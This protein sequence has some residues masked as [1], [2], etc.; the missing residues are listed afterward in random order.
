MRFFSR[1]ASL[2]TRFARAFGALLALATVNVVAFTWGANQRAATFEVLHEAVARHSALT[3]ARTGLEDHAK[4]VKVVS[5]LFGVEHAALS[6]AERQATLRSIDALREQ[7]A[8]VSDR[9]A[10]RDAL[11][12]ELATVRAR[13]DSL[14]LSWGRFYR[15]QA[16]DPGGAIAEVAVTAEPLARQ[17]LGTDLPAAIRAEHDRVD[18]ATAAF[19]RT[20]RAASVLM[21]AILA[22]SGL[23]GVALA[24][25]LSRDLLRDIGA[26]KS[27]VERFGAGEL[28]YRVSVEHSE[29]LEEVGESLNA[30]AGRLRQAQIDLEARNQELAH[31]AYRDPLTH[32]ANRTLFRQRVE[33]ALGRVPERAGE[34]FVLFIDLDD[35]K[36]VNDTLG[37]AAGDRLLVD[38]ASRLL[39]ATRGIDTV[40]RLGGDEFAILL[41]QV[42]GV[43]DAVIVAERVIGA[44]QAPFRLDARTVHVGASVGI[45]SGRDGRHAV[46]HADELLRNA[47]VAMYRAK[48]AGRGCHAVFEPEMHAAL[49]DRV[50]LEQ[51]LRDALR[52]DELTVGFQPI[53]ELATGRV[54]GF[55]ALARWTHARRGVVPPSVFVPLAEETGA[56]LALGRWMLAR[57]CREAVR[58]QAESPDGHPIGVSVNVSGRQVEDPSFVSDLRAVL[59]STGLAPA[60]LTLEITETV[61]MRESETT[62]RWLHEIKALGVRVAIDDFGTGYSSL[63]YLQHFPVDV[64]KIDKAFV[65]QIGEGRNDAAIARTIVTLAEM[66]GLRTV[67]EGIERP[68]QHA[69]LRALGCQLGQGFLYA[70]PL[71]PAEA[72]EFLRR[73]RSAA[74]GSE[75]TVRRQLVMAG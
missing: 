48:A 72:L 16:T 37:H 1:R 67:A 20:D 36:S 68:E 4:R 30:M 23:C 11:D 44:M 25:A 7:L 49:L 75:V 22:L 62:R 38:V 6:R 10:D 13:V 19:Q 27:G 14:T 17:L 45:A 12:A 41:P 28:A 64:L 21:W 29:E 8:T 42:R 34:L 26:L 3:E 73:R 51:E 66:L 24:Y 54:T 40:A 9:D 70:R 32:L 59:A 69:G 50:E 35:F 60:C 63:A 61:I 46:A 15:M 57:A 55:E 56:V 71:P 18:R 53:V 74:E 2:R 47:D 52:R 65:D 5:D 33:R 58:W 31:L 43:E 39:N